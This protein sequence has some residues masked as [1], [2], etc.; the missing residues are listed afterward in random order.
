MKIFKLACLLPAGCVLASFAW[1]SGARPEH[2]FSKAD[3][4]VAEPTEDAASLPGAPTDPG[5]SL[6]QPTPLRVHF[7][8]VG[9]GDC[10]WIQTGDDHIDGKGMLEGYNIIIDAGDGGK[11]GRIDGYSFVSDYLIQGDRLQEG[12]FI[13]WV[14]VTHAHSDHIGGMPGVFKDYHVR[15]VLDPGFD[16]QKKGKKPDKDRP[17]TAYGKF[18]GAVNAETLPDGSKANF[19]WGIPDGFDLDWGSELD[20]QI[21]WSSDVI[22]AADPHKDMNNTSIVIRLGLTDSG[23]DA[24]FLFTGDAEGFVESRLIVEFGAE[25]QSH[26][27]KAGHHGSDSSTSVSFLQAVQPKHII[28]CSGNQSFGGTM[29]P[30]S[31]T[32]ARIELVSNQLNL[33]TEV[34]RTDRDDKSPLKETGTEGGDDTIL[35]TTHGK[36][37]DL[38]IEYVASSIVS[39]TR[40]QATTLAGTQCKRKPKPGRQFCW[41]HLPD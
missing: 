11:F 6:A 4:V 3:V 37:S 12:S 40:C 34:W 1:V 26:V 15:N 19:V 16:K 18:H 29:L 38:V 23:N 36:V 8:D 32:F 24:S 21:L 2:A 41:Q 20:V 7:I 17:R 22:P 39:V 30:R 33:D 25:L 10:I 35:V 28:I 9:T 13:E 27:L 5:S 14:V 31:D